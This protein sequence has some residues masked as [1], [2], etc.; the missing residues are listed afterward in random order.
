MVSYGK[1]L[2]LAANAND[3]AVFQKTE[4]S[5]DNIMSTTGG[6]NQTVYENHAQDARVRQV[7]VVPT[8]SAK[9]GMGG[10]NLPIVTENIPNKDMCVRGGYNRLVL[11]DQGGSVMD[12]S[13]NVTGTLRAEMGGHQPIVMESIPDVLPFNTTNIT[14]KY[15]GSNPQ[16][17]DPCHTL[18]QGDHPPA[19][20]YSFDS[21][22]SNSMKSANPDSGCREVD[23]AKTLDTTVPDPSKNQGGVAVVY[24]LEGNGA[25]KSHRGPGFNESDKMFTL[26]TVEQ[27]AVAYCIAGPMVDRETTMHGTG[28]SEEVSSTL[29]A[30]DRHAVSHIYCMG[31]D[32]RDTRYLENQANPLTA[33][34]YKQ[35][36][37]VGIAAVDC[38][39]NRET[40]KNGTLQAKST[41]GIGVNFN[42]VVRQ[43]YVVRRLTPTECELL[44]GLEPG[45]TLID[46]KSCSDSARYKAL[47]NG[48]AQPC[49]D[50]VLRRLVEEVEKGNDNA[51][52][53]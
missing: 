9:A 32:E 52:G 44:Q 39:N 15:N 16:Y 2:T 38:R 8:L 28:I 24:P 33:C 7:D 47:G 12:V 46:D 13:I 43:H 29:T 22:G 5:H 31:H 4:N 49:A 19:V 18:C 17:G 37:I 36:P 27:H 41:G 20:V 50:F 40:D 26:N 45:Y 6:Q 48:M 1:S 21:L 42:N 3:Q 53:N 30:A 34:D 14:N 23:I 51:D 10:N 11:N 35:P 25:R